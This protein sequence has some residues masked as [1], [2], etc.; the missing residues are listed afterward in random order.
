MHLSAGT[1]SADIA[2]RADA[3]LRIY[4]EFVLGREKANS[5]KVD[6]VLDVVSDGDTDLL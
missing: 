6:S 5:R 1:D 2:E 4:A 3:L